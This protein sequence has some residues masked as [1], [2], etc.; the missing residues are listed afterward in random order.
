MKKLG[1][2]ILMILLGMGMVFAIQPAQSWTQV[3]SGFYNSSPAANLTT[4]GGNVTAANIAGNVSTTKWAGLYGN[5]SAG[6]VLTPGGLTNIFYKWTWTPGTNTGRLC[7]TPGTTFAWASAAGATASS[8]D[9]TWTFAANAT[10]SAAN[11]LND[12]CNTIGTVAGQTISSSAATTTGTGGG[13][14]FQTCAIN[15]GASSVKGD[16]AFCNAIDSATSFDSDTSNYELI[17]PTNSTIG[18]TETY[19]AWLELD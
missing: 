3:S 9:T 2:G 17:V 15:D 7:V 18:S 16:F 4:Q 12:T 8:I 5:V 11:T 6:L 14:T 13:D 10:D 19:Y 1:I